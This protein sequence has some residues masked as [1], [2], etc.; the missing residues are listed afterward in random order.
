VLAIVSVIFGFWPLG[1]VAILASIRAMNAFDAG[2]HELGYF[3]ARRSRLFSILSIVIGAVITI[4]VAILI[5][6]SL[7]AV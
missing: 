6:I 2:N 3:Y 5:G 1:I 4:A 7:A